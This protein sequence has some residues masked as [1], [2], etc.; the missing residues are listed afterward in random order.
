MIRKIADFMIIPETVE[1]TAGL[2][3]VKPLFF[4]GEQDCFPVIDEGQVVGVLSWQ[5]TMRAHPNRIAADAMGGKFIYVESDMPLWRA[6]ELMEQDRL[7]ALLVCEH[8]VLKGIVTPAVIKQE[9]GKHTDLLTGLYKTDY[10]YYNAL[11]LMASGHEI[12]LA[13]AD[14][15]NFGEINK[16]YGHVK[17]D[18]IL[19]EFGALLQAHTPTGSIL[20][21]YGG[22]EFITLMSCC[23]EDITT[24]A[25]D[26]RQI[27]AGYHFQDNIPVTMSVGVA[28]AGRV[29]D[30]SLP[31]GRLLTSLINKASLAS[32]AAKK[33]S[34]GLKT[35]EQISESE[36]A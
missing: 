17:G 24:F 27:V 30:R 3:Q 32:S 23:R 18:L 21:R 7:S 28:T 6:K 20:C 13:F 4:K 1:A 35:L 9:L 8:D 34:S 10:L 31:H 2:R 33:D 11:K 15:D 19:K 29:S 22:D 12:S 5:D 16:Q 36:S 26:L 14:I 25:H